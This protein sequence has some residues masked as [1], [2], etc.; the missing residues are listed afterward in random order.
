MEWI[1]KNRTRE[2]SAGCD[3]SIN[4][5]KD[6]MTC[7][8]FKNACHGKLSTTGYIQIG[9]EGNRLYFQETDKYHGFKLTSFNKTKDSC[10]VKFNSQYL[11]PHFRERADYKLKLDDDMFL[12][13]IDVTERME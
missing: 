10:H 1:Q 3:V 5:G 2:A 7:I 4:T 13:Y 8:T 12:Y 6:K 11:K 9:Q